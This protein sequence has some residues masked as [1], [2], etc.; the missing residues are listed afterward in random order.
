VDKCGYIYAVNAKL[1]LKIKVFTKTCFLIGIQE[2]ATSR[3]Y[4][5]VLEVQQAF[6]R[7]K[8][9]YSHRLDQFKLVF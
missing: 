9:R 1:E 3:L 6:P 2:T 7:Q 8:L 4:S 5:A